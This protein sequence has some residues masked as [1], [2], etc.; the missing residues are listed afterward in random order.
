[1]IKELQAEDIW[2]IMPI[3]EKFSTEAKRELDPEV[4]T[5]AWERL[6]ESGVATIFVAY[7]NN[8]SP[9][10]VFGAA[11]SNDLFDGTPYATEMFWFVD[12]VKRGG[13]L[14]LLDHFEKWAID[15]DIKRMAMVHLT[16]LMPDRLKSLYEKR[17][18]VSAETH[19]I[20]EV[21]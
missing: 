9:T 4:F 12:P 2:T 17:G 3:L 19:Y 21:E 14:R 8:D 11:K 10:G 18:Y 6:I 13:G 16:N 15:H 7:D 20:K 5:V 1:M